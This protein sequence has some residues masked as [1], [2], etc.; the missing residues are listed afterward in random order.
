M[1]RYNITYPESREAQRLLGAPLTAASTV[2]WPRAVRT[3]HP[4]LT[5]I[6][7]AM[8]MHGVA[9]GL[10]LTFVRVPQPSPPLEPTITLV[11]EAPQAPPAAAPEPAAPPAASPAP[12]PQAAAPPP[13]APP[14]EQPPPP[15]AAVPPPEAPP[16]EQPPPPEPPPVEPP[17]PPVEQAPAQAKPTEPPR[18]R[19]VQRPAVRARPAAPARIVEPP[20]AA[21]TE[22]P[23]SARPAQPARE[24]PISTDWQRSLA[25]W[26][27]AHKTYPEFARQRGIEGSVVLRF[28]AARSGQVLSV[29]VARSAGSPVLD[30]AAE[31]LVRDA[32][33]PPFPAGMPQQTATVTVTL[34][35]TLTN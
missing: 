19:A 35:Y 27:T 33:L 1:L 17:P 24:A 4:R 3:K 21:A 22:S 18:P 23:P 14:P 2:R 12:P 5:P 10:A 6:G 32:T 25:A 31:A 9:F 13:A 7:A 8:L 20:A 34:H 16:P 29:S 30:S 28:T 15:Q 11:F 26:L